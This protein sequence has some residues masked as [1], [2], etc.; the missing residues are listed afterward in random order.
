MG[1]VG[2]EVLMTGFVVG[3]PAFGTGGSDMLRARAGHA[4]YCGSFF[5]GAVSPELDEVSSRVATV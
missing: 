3:S 5:R 2:H 1:G 4:G